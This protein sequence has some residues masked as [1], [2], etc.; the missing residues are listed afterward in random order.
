[1]ELDLGDRQWTLRSSIVEVLDTGYPAF[2]SLAITASF[3]G[4]GS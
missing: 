4:R 1:M 3:R 2:R